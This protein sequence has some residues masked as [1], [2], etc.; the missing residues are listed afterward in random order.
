MAVRDH[1]TWKA[2]CQYKY[3]DSLSFACE[4]VAQLD[5]PRVIVQRRDKLAFSFIFLANQIHLRYF[6]ISVDSEA[7]ICVVSV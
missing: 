6:F 4:S 1:M 7:R 3:S 5:Q 2:E